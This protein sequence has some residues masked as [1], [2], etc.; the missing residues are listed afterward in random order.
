MPSPTITILIPAWN[1]A[2]ELPRTLAAIARAA[3]NVDGIEVVVAAGGE[4]GQYEEAKRAGADFT[5]G[6]CTVIPQRPLG[7]MQALR[8][9][10]ETVASR[11]A[12]YLLMLDADTQLAA[13]SLAE[14]VSFLDQ[15]PELVGIGG[16]IRGG[17]AGVGAA[18][19][20]V[21]LACQSRLEGLTAVSG[22]AIV[23]RGSALWP[24]WERVFAQHDYPLH[25]DYQVCERM[26]A[27][28]GLSFAVHPAFSMQTPRARGFAFLRAERRHHRAMF[29][30]AP[31]A[32]GGRYLAGA[33]FTSILPIVAPLALPAAL[34]PALWPVALPTAFLSVRR[35]VGLKRRYDL[36]RAVDETVAAVSFGEYLR[37]E[38]VFA[39]SALLGAG[40]RL[41]ARAD[42][43]RFR[44]YRAPG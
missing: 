43:P 6:P 27:L 41:R 13:D 7:K 15:H 23:L 30:R 11:P 42:G 35:I 12:R 26:A 14:A 16:V 32:T 40:D 20:L 33:A 19:D 24:N 18:H 22:G 2:R 29:A 38:W 25:I 5:A 3:A 8:E 4:D 34:L 37:D 10:M 21:N 28:T 1:D 9:A 17:A 31:V 44:G 36:A 39:L